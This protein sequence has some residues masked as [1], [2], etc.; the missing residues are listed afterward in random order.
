MET[1]WLLLCLLGH[2]CRLCE[3]CICLEMLCPVHLWGCSWFLK[4]RLPSG[5]LHSWTI[6]SQYTPHPAPLVMVLTQHVYFPSWWWL[7]RA[8]YYYHMRFQGMFPVWT[9]AML[10]CRADVEWW[11]PGCESSNRASTHLLLGSILIAS[12]ASG[13]GSNGNLYFSVGKKRSVGVRNASEQVT[14]CWTKDHC[15]FGGFP[16]DWVVKNL[17]AMQETRVWPLGREDLLEKGLVTHSR[18]LA[19]EIPW[20]EEPGRC[21]PWGCKELDTTKW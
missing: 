17:P 14:G 9:V 19:W 16:C 11:V 20:T 5:S 4:R 15:F 2:P 6:L 18:I 12:I 8:Q 10:C 7:W 1:G 21:S 3:I 13:F